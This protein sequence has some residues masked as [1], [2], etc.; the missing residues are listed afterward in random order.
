MESQLL[1]DTDVR[2][3]A[4]SSAQLAHQPRVSGAVQVTQSHFKSTPCASGRSSASDA[5]APGVL[6]QSASSN[7][8]QVVNGP[9]QLFY[10]LNG[11]FVVHS[12]AGHWVV[13]PDTVLQ[14]LSGTAYTIRKAD[15]ISVR[16]ITLPDVPSQGLKAENCVYSLTPLLRELLEAL[17]VTPAKHDGNTGSK[18]LLLAELLA[19][20]DIRRNEITH[21][22]RSMPSDPRI[23]QICNY[24]YDNLDAPRTLQEWATELNN[25]TR[26]LHRLFLREFGI[27]FVQWRQQTR[28]MA[29][30]EWLA[31]GRPIMDVALDLGY[32]TQSAFAAMFRRN[33]GLTPTEWQEKRRLPGR[34]VG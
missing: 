24:V 1:S 6:C 10:S 26:T 4:V 21:R 9:G 20:S 31:E 3:V 11:L 2:P 8:E 14:L 33:T 30:L 5:T 16:S 22:C 25:D 15:P 19:E 29:A 12:D 28:L 17:Y 7:D 18:A 27:S 32:Q 34:R 23:A 13:Q